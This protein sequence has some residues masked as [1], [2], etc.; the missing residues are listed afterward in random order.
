MYDFMD[1]KEEDYKKYIVIIEG[2]GFHFSLYFFIY[3]SFSSIN[4]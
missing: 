3:S 4:L 2:I 1:E